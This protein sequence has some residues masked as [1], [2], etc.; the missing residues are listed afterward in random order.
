MPPSAPKCAANKN[1]PRRACCARCARR[2]WPY[3][4]LAL[5]YSRRWAEHFEAL[6]IEEGAA[7]RL[8]EESTASLR[9]QAALESDDSIG[10]EAYLEA[11]YDQYKALRM[12]D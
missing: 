4:R 6:G 3:F 2:D 1:C 8:S 10:F 7:Q 12:S 9:R 11:Y 5:D